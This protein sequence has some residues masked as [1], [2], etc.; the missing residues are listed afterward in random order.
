MKTL[1]PL[2]LVAGLARANF[3]ASAADAAA[4]APKKVLFFS[5]SSGFEHT[6]IKPETKDG[7]NG[8]AFPVLRQLGEK[9]NIEF[10]F[11]RTAAGSHPSIS[12]SS[13]ASVSTPAAI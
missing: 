6:A 2:T 13:T 7:K 3:T 10:T 11:P 12:R 4:P 1:L 5:K 9:N 8:F